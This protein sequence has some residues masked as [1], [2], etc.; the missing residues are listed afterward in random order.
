MKRL[1]LPALLLLLAVP[2][3]A[4]D[5]P[6]KLDVKPVVVPLEVLKTRHLAINVK[7]NGKGPYRMIFDTGAPVTLISSKVARESGMV[8]KDVKG[9]PLGLFGALGQHPIQTLEVGDLKAEKIPAMVMDHPAVAALGK[10]LGPLEGI[11]GYP[12]FARYTMTIDYEKQQLTLVPNG[13]EPA[14]IMESLM[15]TL[16]AGKAPPAQ[17]VAPAAQF[18]LVV[19]KDEGDEEAGIVVEAVRPGSAADAA[20]VKAGDR[21]LSLGGRWTESVLDCYRAAAAVKPGVAVPVEVRRGGKDVKLT[22]TPRAGL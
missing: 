15:N 17:V 5:A 4:E 2:T 8:G 21:L 18:G 7:I 19:K 13:H 9:P 12:F 10:A 20:G 22:V 6:K 11:V 14:D 16:M 1:L 3:H